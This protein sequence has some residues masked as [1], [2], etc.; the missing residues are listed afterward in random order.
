MFERLR[1]YTRHS[2]NDLR[3]NGR[4]TVFALLCI[5]AGVAAIVSLQTL[6]VMMNN[7][8]TGS[9]Q[10]TNRGDLRVNPSSRWANY[11]IDP[12]EETFDGTYVFTPEGVA[13]IQ[14]WLDTNYPGSELTYRQAIKGFGVAWSASIPARDTYKAF[15]YNF[16]IDAQTYPLYGTVK[17]ENGKRLAD[18]LQAPTDIVISRN[19]ADDLEAQVGDQLRLPG[20]SQ[21]FTVRGI[22]PTDTEGG[23]LNFAAHIFGYFYLDQ[24]S[25]TLFQDLTPGEATTLFIRL[26]NPDQVDIAA[27]KLDRLS[28]A[29]DITSTTDLREINTEISDTVDDL[30]VVM[31]LL[32]VLIGGIGIVNTMLVIVSRRTTEVAVLKTLGLEP[33]EVIVLFLV[34]AILMGILGSLLGILGGWVLAYAVK[35]IAEAFLG[36]NL[37]FTIALVPA[38]NGFVVGIIITAIFGFLPT[39]AAGQIRPANVLRPN[40]TIIPRTGRLSAFAAIMV[41]VL[42]LSLVAQGL[43]AGVLGNPEIA[44][45]LRLKDITGGL[46]AFYGLLIAVPLVMSGI[47]SMRERR[48]GRSWFLQVLRWL[49]TLVI[50]PVL[51][52]LFGYYVPAIAILT[53]TVILVGY[54]YIALWMVIWAVGG[55]RFREIFPGV[56]V[57]L[58]PL[59]WPLI[60][61]LIVLIIPT[62]VL[63]WLI[64]RFTFVDLKLAMR[65]M[66]A[67]KGR[68]ASTLVA[69]VVGVFTLS[70]ITMMVDTITQTFQNL[71]EDVAGGNILVLSAGGE[72]TMGEVRAVFEE[73]PDYVRSYAIIAN[74]NTR[75]TEYYDTSVQ[76]VSNRARSNGWWFD[77]VDG[78]EISSNLPDLKFLAGRN[79]DPALDSAPDA[80]GYWS[81]VAIKGQEETPPV[82]LGVGDTLVF[83]LTGGQVK[84]RIVGVAEQG[85]SIGDSNLYAPLAAFEGYKSNSIFAIADVKED[86]IKDIRRSLAKVPGAFV[87]ETR[88]INDL[89]NRVIGQFTSFPILVAALALV[90]GGVVIANAVALSTLER[91]RE[92]GVMKA[93]GLQR[94]R[95]LGMLLLENGLMGI[96]GGLIGVGISF[97]G[98]VISLSSSDL[99][100]NTAIPYVTAFSLMGLCILISLGAAL[101]SVWGASG[102]KPLNVLRYE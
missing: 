100:S 66:L 62:W 33:R 92:I 10:E 90:T 51:G 21:D 6:A 17:A 56:L 69:L 3:V 16:I 19:L 24:S 35:G 30:V 96:V 44:S 75:L 101:L 36:Q 76:Q 84:F 81:L 64:Q 18:L 59:F 102:E 42:A 85:L 13:H 87:L 94:E 82:D 1:F 15:I 38:V 31:G 49:G 71:L 91:R 58:F 40:E 55:G 50:V 23:F 47:A 4:R 72:Q 97:V 27:K 22:V 89:V 63:G 78:R 83:S 26:K 52:G 12:E 99:G 98:L 48:R 57:L 28:G 74:Y 54:L 20:A 79:L 39:L 45:G 41:L 86:H 14:E 43:L 65:S 32:S 11:V 95:V 34:E 53:L 61:V 29:L 46:G 70:L 80:E 8:L 77:S 2:V 68:G 67:T 25:T 88:L 9:L 37:A 60:P 73:N 7:A 93:I 5:A